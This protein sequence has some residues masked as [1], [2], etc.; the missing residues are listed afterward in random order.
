[1]PITPVAVLGMS[2]RERLT[3]VPRE[4]T[5]EPNLVVG[6][7]ATVEAYS[8]AGEDGG[9]LGGFYSFGVAHMCD[10][11]EPGDTVVDLGC[12]PAHHLIETARVNPESRFIG[13]DLS[14]TMLAAAR[15]NV[16]RAGLINVELRCADMSR[17]HELDDESADAVVSSGALHH[18]PTYNALERTL[19]EVRRILKP[20][21]GV[22]LFDFCRLR[23]RRNLEAFVDANRDLVHELVLR[24]YADSMRAAFSRE[25]L[26]R[27]ARALQGAARPFVTSPVSF[28]LAFKS[29]LRAH[30]D[31]K[32]LDL[33]ARRRAAL[34]PHAKN[35]LRNLRLAFALGGLRSS[36]L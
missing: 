5:P 28:A 17:L 15:R 3:H 16:D 35:D 33:V 21:G 23:S 19:A 29:A 36:W 2:V 30:K 18:L 27:A 14:E 11:I 9:A 34:S 32:R 22:F 31:E 24:D 20:G 7:A 6:D 1:M 13:I 26:Q 25:E 8:G 10:V 12:G 4:R